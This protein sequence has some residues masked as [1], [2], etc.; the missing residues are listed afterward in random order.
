MLAAETKHLCIYFA[1]PWEGWNRWR[2][3]SSE[4]VFDPL[5]SSLCRCILLPPPPRRSASVP[6]F[7]SP[8][9][10]DP[11]IWFMFSFCHPLF[12]SLLKTP[13]QVWNRLSSSSLKYVWI[14]DYLSNRAFI[15]QGGYF[16]KLTKQILLT[17]CEWGKRW[18]DQSLV[19]CFPE[20][21]LSG[22]GFSSSSSPN[23]P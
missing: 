4:L 15:S 21:L 7:L 11:L 18:L 19:C 6:V 10:L 13:S 5:I 20:K 16:K 22:S 2:E 1:D 23:T 17:R 14:L 8:R 3:K 9:S 12:L